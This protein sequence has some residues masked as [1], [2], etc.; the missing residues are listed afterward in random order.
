MDYSIDSFYQGEAAMMINYSHHI[1][2]IKDKT[3]Y[4][5]FGTSMVPQIKGREINV[6]YANYW[7]PTVSIASENSEWAWHFL[8][9][10]STKDNASKY[11]EKSKR[12][13]S[14]RDLIDGQ[15]DYIYFGVFERQALTA[16]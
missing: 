14:R 10:L 11:L 15:K 6:T 5:N 8:Q 4:L 7:V 3:P 12:P 1:D 2:T 16:R 9:F 13:A